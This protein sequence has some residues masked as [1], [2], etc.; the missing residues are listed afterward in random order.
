M[1]RRLRFSIWYFVAALAVVILVHTYLIQEQA[2][3]VTYAQ[4]KQLVQAEKVT[5]VVVG[6]DY[7]S[8]KF[9][10]LDLDGILTDEQIKHLRQVPGPGKTLLARDARE[11]HGTPARGRL[12][13]GLLTPVR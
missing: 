7:A 13:R 12:A 10:T 11:P 8:G 1:E 2:G 5:D 3:E 6:P 4:F 9:T